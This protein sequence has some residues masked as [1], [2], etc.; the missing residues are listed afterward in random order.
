M[1][2]GLDGLR[3]RWQI[4]SVE[5][6][7]AA[8][9]VRVHVG[10]RADANL[11]CPL[12]GAVG[13]I[14]DHRSREWR[15]LDACEYRTRLV[16]EVPRMRCPEHGVVTTQVTWAATSSRYTV[17]FAIRVIDWLKEASVSAVSRQFDLNWNVIDGIKQRAVRRGLTRRT[18]TCAAARW[19]DETAFKKRHN[20]VTVGSDHVTGTVLHGAEDRKAASLS[21]C[22]AGLTADDIAGIRSVSMD[23]WPAFITAT[24]WFVPDADRKIAFDRFPIAKHLGAAVDKVG[25][26]EHKALLRAGDTTLT[27]SK[28]KWLQNPTTRSGRQ[29]QDVK[30][31]RAWALKELA[32]SLWNY[33]SRTW[34]EKGW[35]RWL[36]GAVRCRLLPMVAAAK[37]IKRHL[38]ASSTPSS[39]RSATA[40]PRASTAAS[41]R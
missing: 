20:D 6:C 22:Y 15:H 34:A 40:R 17:A 36:R 31:P 1:F 28:Y 3:D 19:V 5:V 23:L 41:N 39:S 32:Q 37:M 26:R 38:W 8:K 18:T 4:V 30:S 33:G 14:Y 25:R 16:A 13:T 24:P 11:H 35:Q 10:R 29:K 2:E 27:G 9:I 12:C 7:D 21:A